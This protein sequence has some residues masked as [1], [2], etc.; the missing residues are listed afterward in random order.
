MKIWASF[1][2]C[3]VFYFDDILAY[4]RH[5]QWVAYS[6][7]NRVVV[8]VHKRELLIKEGYLV[9]Y[10]WLGKLQVRHQIGLCYRVG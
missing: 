3:E 5:A 7:L 4:K 8:N 2:H 1:K 9:E 6:H 10:C